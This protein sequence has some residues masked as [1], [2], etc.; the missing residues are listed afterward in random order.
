VTVAGLNF[1]CSKPRI[2]HDFGIHRR[3]DAGEY[4]NLPPLALENVQTTA[5]IA[6]RSR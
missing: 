2:L 6:P 1:E 5:E 3:L 4:S